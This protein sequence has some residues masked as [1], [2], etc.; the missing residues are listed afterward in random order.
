V[1]R[2]AVEEFGDCLAEGVFTLL[3]RGLAISDATLGY[4]QKF[5]GLRA[6]F[7]GELIDRILLTDKPV[8]EKRRIRAA[9]TAA[10]DRSGQIEPELCIA[11]L[12]AWLADRDLWQRHV[13]DRLDQFGVP[14]GTEVA[15][16]LS[17]LGLLECSSLTIT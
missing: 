15:K 7:I 17:G 5:L 8:D 1:D 9:L 3:D 13:A 16:V 12:Q 2:A 14:A 6:T 4:W 10:G 11:Y